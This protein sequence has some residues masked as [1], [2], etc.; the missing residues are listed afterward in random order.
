M[1][2]DNLEVLKIINF[3]E[4]Y[5]YRHLS[6]EEIIAIKNELNGYSYDKFIANIKEP[7]LT[8]TKFFTIADLFRVI[9]SQKDSENFL[10]NSGIEEWDELYDN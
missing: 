4:T 1:K 9:D 7:L 3:I 2:E 6:D 10:K 8:S 5:Y